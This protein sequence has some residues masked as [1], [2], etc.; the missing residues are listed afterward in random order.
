M[1]R[2]GSGILLMFE[3]LLASG[4]GA[5]T[6][7]EGTDSVHVTIPRRVVHPGV[8][9]LLADVDER[10][11]LMQRERIALAMLA[12]TEGLAMTELQRRLEL[13][14]PEALSSWIARLVELGLVE[15]VGRT[16]GT[17][18]FVS[19]VLLRS[20]GLDDRTTLARIEPHRLRAL[21]LEDLKRYPNSNRVDLHRRIGPEINDK[22]IVRM[23]NVLISENLVVAIGSRRWRTYHLAATSGGQEP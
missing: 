13:D 4:R 23:L 12:Q 3:R 2:E 6:V 16:K 17:R 21:I 8:I 14:D 9:R 11:Q 15:Q 10:Y 7:R 19:P 22:A 5:P 18:Y 20:A 1:E